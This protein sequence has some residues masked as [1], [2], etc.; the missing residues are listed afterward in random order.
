MNEKLSILC[1]EVQTK[2]IFDNIDIT[3]CIT[4]IL[5]KITPEGPSVLLSVLPS[6]IDISN[7][8]KEDTK[9]IVDKGEM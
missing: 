2:V 1:N 7:I 6:V 3:S 5:I 8:D 4:K 9:I